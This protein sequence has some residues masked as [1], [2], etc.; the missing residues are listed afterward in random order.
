[1]LR[2]TA[3]PSVTVNG[4]EGG[5]PRLQKTVLPVEAQANVSIRLAPGQSTAE[6]APVFERLLRETRHPT[7]AT[8]DVELWSTGE[9]GYVD[10][11]APAVR[12]ALDAFEHVARHAARPRPVGRLDPRRRRARRARRAGDRDGLRA[13]DGSQLHSPNENIPASAL[14][15]GLETTVELLRRFSALGA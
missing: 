7:G 10:P 14:R 4:I 15:D 13:A 9:P 2:T 11:A 3:E 12:L 6:I 8:V 1:M 5:S